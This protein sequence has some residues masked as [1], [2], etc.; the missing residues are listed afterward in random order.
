MASTPL[1]GP[2]IHTQQVEFYYPAYEEDL[3][4]NSAK[5]STKNPTPMA[6]NG[7]DL[8]IKK[9]EFV[10]IL[11]HN[12]CGKSTLA[13]HFNGLLAPTK[14][15][16]RVKGL[17]T[18][19]PA[20]TWAIRQSTGMLFQNPDNQIVASIVEEDV[21]FGPENIG[22]PSGEII[23]RVEEA[24]KTVDMLDY[25]DAQPHH[26]SGG[27][28]QRVAIAGV[29]A[30]APEAIVLDEPTA[31]LDPT[32]RREVLNAVM[33][34]NKNKQLTLV[35]I[36]HFMEEAALADRIIVMDKGKIVLEGPPH[37]VFAQHQ[38]MEALGLGVPVTTALA[39]ALQ[40]K[41]IP[42]TGVP[43][44]T[45]QFLAQPAIAKKIDEITTP[46]ALPLLAEKDQ[47][48]KNPDAPPALALVNL[49]HVYSP[50]SVY[51]KVAIQDL[52]MRIP[53]G[54]MVAIIGHTG[55]G[56]STLIQHF[57]ALL[58]PTSGQVL[59]GGVDIH[60]PQSPGLDKV[61]QQVGLV[62]QYPEHQLFE[63]TV[64]KDV[65]FGPSKM[66]LL[67]DEI[68]SRVSSAL[69]TVGIDETLFEKSPFELSGGQKRRVAI[70]GVLAMQPDILIL[71]EPAAG[72]DPKGKDE[73]LSQIKSLHQHL[74]IT[75]ILVS[76]SMDDVAKLAN[77][78][79]VMNKGQ[80]MCHGHPRDVFSQ[81]DALRAVGLDVPQI[82]RLF[83]QIN[84][85]NPHI[86]KDVLT[87]SEAVHIL[88]GGVK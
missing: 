54:G 50:G 26:L 4:T 85:I 82:N 81:A 29:L 6:L 49:Q 64:F 23:Q 74:G 9:G 7:I 18:K 69:A 5:S 53:Q 55:S 88:A 56:K 77:T 39:V 35:L 44:D 15:H 24:L 68:N 57:N 59:V 62:F 10:A 48:Q 14:G 43:L 78:L 21:A 16:V 72:L 61:R 1:A 79:Y 75:V 8:Q 11:G 34:L 2:Y 31:M 45:Q 22:I 13:R 3:D 86:P 73:I 30:M 80:L 84:K 25:R 41:G 51:Q 33:D 32:G 76:H 65:A 47:A 17:D 40:E 87:I 38:Q 60:G 71:D 46:M 36:T 58:K 37:T 42:F 63:A 70:A 20:H 83:T 28:K 66:G 67:P 19:D 52:N 12:G 27:Q